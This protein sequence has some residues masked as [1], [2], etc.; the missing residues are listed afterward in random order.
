MSAIRM[1]S[2]GLLQAALAL[3]VGVALFSF[4]SQTV[5]AGDLPKQGNFTLTWTGSGTAKRIGI[6]GDHEAWLWEYT[7]ITMN[8]AGEG[9]MHNMSNEGFGVSLGDEFIG[10]DVYTDVDG[11]QIFAVGKEEVYGKGTETFLGGTGKYEGIQGSYEYDFTDLPETSEAV[12]H[13]VGK[14]WGSYTLP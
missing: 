8:D 7:V 9:F 13:A 1:L 14:K 2:R 5:L 11:D 10:Y 6:S 3:A 12:W 4:L